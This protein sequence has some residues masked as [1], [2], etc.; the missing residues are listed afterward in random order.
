[1]SSTVKKAVREIF[2]E[3]TKTKSNLKRVLHMSESGAGQRVFPPKTAKNDEKFGLRLD[4]GEPVKGKPGVIRL[5]LQ[6][7]SN[8]KNKIIREIAQKDSHRVL[9]SV[10]VDTKQEAN[11]DNA[12]KVRDQL[13]GKL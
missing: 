3:I 10:D 9:A 1:M 7:N 5:N 2:E 11:K 8:A 6:A 4:K 12:A 13:I